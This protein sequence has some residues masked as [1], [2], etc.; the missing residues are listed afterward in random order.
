MNFALQERTTPNSELGPNVAGNSS[1]LT[2]FEQKGQRMGETFDFSSSTHTVR[3]ASPSYLIDIQCDGCCV[4][5]IKGIRFKCGY[6]SVP[7]PTNISGCA[8]YWLLVCHTIPVVAVSVTTTTCAPSV[9]GSLVWFMI[10]YT[11][12]WCCHTPA[13][14]Q[15]LVL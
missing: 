5:P 4:A 14:S 15:N 2:L 10:R 11:P 13:R 9:R 3:T 7:T 12:L 8:V 6:A 1:L